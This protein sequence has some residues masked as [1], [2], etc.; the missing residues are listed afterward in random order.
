MKKIFGLG[1]TI[2]LI[3]STL[4][5]AV[6]ASAATAGPYDYTPGVIKMIGVNETTSL[7]DGKATYY[8]ATVN[9][10]PHGLKNEFNFLTTHLVI[11]SENTKFFT[12]SADSSDKLNYSTK[13]ISQLVKD[14]EAENPAYEVVAAINADFFNTRTG[15]PEEPMMQN[16]KMLKTFV[17]PESESRGRGLVGI[18]DTTGEVVYHTIGQVY[19]DGGYGTDLT[20]KADYQVQVL[21]PNKTNAVA[22]YDSFLASAPST[23]KISFTTSD[24]GKGNYS[25]STVYV[26]QLDRYRKDTGSKNN[27]KQATEDYY[28]AEGTIVDI[29]AGTADMKPESGKAYIA[30]SNK[31]QA[32]QLRKGATVRCQRVLTGDWENVSNAI[33]F[34]Q[35][36][37][38]EGQLMFYNAYGRNHTGDGASESETKKWTEDIYDYPHCWKARTAIGFKADGTPVLMV[39]PYNKILGAT[40]YEMSAQFKALGCTNAFLLDGGGSSTMV[41]RCEDGLK[42]AHNAEAGTNNEGRA[43]ANAVILAVLKDGATAPAKDNTPANKVTLDTAIAKAETLKKED[44]PITDATWSAF[45][46]CLSEA[47]AVADNFSSTQEAVDGAVASL[48]KLTADIEAAKNPSGSETEAPATDAPKN[49]TETKAPEKNTDAPK[50]DDKKESGCGSSMALSAL[51]TAGVVGTAFIVKK[52]KE[53]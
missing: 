30:V 18:N 44:Y 45:T 23:S 46:A 20:Y 5:A 24:Y 33:G 19:K 25:G 39:I 1:V 40:Y 28:F 3:L 48:T 12:Y 42:I 26:V 38:L 13:T 37:L 29:I 50:D 7:A 11:G 27:T 21:G 53:D 43:V 34:K 4:L 51:A 22:S 15:E 41:I 9:S 17:L 52:K 2:L 16:G 14:F 10:S 8:K 47:K 35:Q 31:E 49:E 6:P 32:P 36:I